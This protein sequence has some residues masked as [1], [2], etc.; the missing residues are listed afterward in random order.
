MTTNLR[1]NEYPRR[2]RK[3]RKKYITSLLNRLAELERRSDPSGGTNS[4]KGKDLAAFDAL[5]TAG[6]LVRTVAGWAIDHQAGLA[7]EELSFVPLRPSQTKQHPQYR[8]Q[9]D[10]VDDHKHERNSVNLVRAVDPRVVRR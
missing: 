8:A 10:A 4:A 2:K 6:E 7:V 5:E 3:G 1:S 9:R